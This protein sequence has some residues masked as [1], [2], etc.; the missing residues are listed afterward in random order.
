MCQEVGTVP[1]LW[2]LP[3]A[4][5]LLSFIICFDRPA[6]YRRRFF[7]P[8]SA[9]LGFVALI[10]ANQTFALQ[11]IPQLAL[12]SIYFFFMC[13]TA[14]GELVH[15]RPGPAHLTL[16]YLAIAAGGAMGSILVAVGA[17]ALFQDYWEFYIGFTVLWLALSWAWW[18]DR[19]SPFHTG[20]PLH[21]HVFLFLAVY[22]TVASL[23]T[24]WIPFHAQLPRPLPVS[25]AVIVAV[26]VIVTAL[27]VRGRLFLRRPLWSRWLA[28]AVIVPSAL[29]LIVRTHWINRTR[30]ASGR[31]FYGVV[32]ISRSS[33]REEGPPYLQVRQ[34]QDQ[35]RQIPKELCH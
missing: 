13:M 20:D 8:T 2:I 7:I 6:W 17:P 34:L 16:F 19:S 24:A 21:F 1:L 12:Y 29:F 28:V 3:L 22:F 30:L 10:V 26:G 11:L 31:N 4:I 9:L 15:S 25:L 5:Y 33:P 18:H 35:N 14:H 27:L 32:R 23:P